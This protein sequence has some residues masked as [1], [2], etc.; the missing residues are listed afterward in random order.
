MVVRT[1]T[2]RRGA[3]A[4]E[5]LYIKEGKVYPRLRVFIL[6]TALQCYVGIEFRSLADVTSPN[7]GNKKTVSLDS[8]TKRSPPN[9]VQGYLFRLSQLRLATVSSDPDQISS[10]SA[11]KRSANGPINW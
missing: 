3:R 11:V 6:R 10:I 9:F 8:R 7:V 1:K 2:F 5:A 4:D